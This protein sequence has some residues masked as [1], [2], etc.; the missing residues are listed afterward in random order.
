MINKNPIGGVSVG[1]YVDGWV[2][3]QSLKI[4]QSKTSRNYINWSG[5]D[6]N[7]VK[8]WGTYFGPD[9]APLPKFEKGS[10]ISVSGPIGEG[11]AGLAVWA[12]SMT[13]VLDDKDVKEFEY[14]CYPSVPDNELSNYVFELETISKSFTGPISKLSLSL[15]DYF[16]P[17]LYTIPA[18]I[19]IH[20][21]VR[22]GLAK[23]TWD[24][25]KMCEAAQEIMGLD[26]QVL[27]FS[28]LYHDIGKT[29]EYT[30]KITFSKIRGLISHTSIAIQ[31]ITDALITKDICVS[32]N[33]LCHIQH[34][35]LSHHGEFSEINPCTKEANCLH[36]CDNLCAKIGHIS[37]SI[38]R[39]EIGSDGRGKWSKVLGTVPYVPELD[40]SAK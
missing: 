19:D 15:F 5:L 8:I 12:Q 21:P 32:S 18:G 40:D 9:N 6:I 20:E 22:G 27:L 38:R 7:G 14:V 17:Y 39:G 26:R 16:K 13:K 37:E 29:Q 36:Y 23:H 24:V 34:C 4:V 2:L 33:E 25:V 11:K 28:A 3:L 1:E 31:L 35:I 10:V 30:E